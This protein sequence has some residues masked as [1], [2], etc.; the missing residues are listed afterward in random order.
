MRRMIPQK[1]IDAIK[2][3]APLAGK[4]DYSSGKVKVN[5]DFEA[6][7][8]TSKGIANTGALANI[9]DVAISGD[10]DAS[11]D[12][13]AGTLKPLAP[14]WS[15]DL[16]DVVLSVPSGFSATNI[17]S[18]LQVIGGELEIIF[19]FS[20]TNEGEASATPANVQL[21]TFSLPNEIAEKIIDVKGNPLNVSVPSLVA[22]AGARALNTPYPPESATTFAG[23]YGALSLSHAGTQLFIACYGLQTIGAGGTHTY[24]ARI[25]LTLL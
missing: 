23:Q 15:I 12:L 1:L 6:D 4:I 18:R 16:S 22:I 7:G 14:N 25:Q 8:I 5:G 24:S 9:G 3:L 17:F 20:I 13:T 11:G 10:L 21:G 2:S 19:T